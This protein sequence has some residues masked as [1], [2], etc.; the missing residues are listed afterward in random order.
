MRTYVRTSFSA[1]LDPEWRCEM[2]Q[3][4]SARA[5]ICLG[6]FGEGELPVAVGMHLIYLTA[7]G[8]ALRDPRS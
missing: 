7:P 6:Q 4:T 3:A 5:C 2:A 8:A 1:L